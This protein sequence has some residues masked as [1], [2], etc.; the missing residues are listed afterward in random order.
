MNN[1]ISIERLIKNAKKK[2]IDFGKGDPY[3]RLRYYTKMGW[4]PHTVRKK[5]KKGDVK[6]HYPAWALDHLILIE[7]LKEKGLSNEEIAKRLSAKN[8]L[9]NFFDLL[10]DTNTRNLVLSYIAFGMIV[11]IFLTE[12]GLLK[13]GKTKDILFNPSITSVTAQILDSGNAFIPTNT[14]SVFIKTSFINRNMKVNVTFNQDYYPATRYWIEEIKDYEG[15]IIK[16]DSPVE[17]NPD[18]NWWVTN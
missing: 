10:K 12:M 17:N 7:E 4:L 2:G 9:V 13:I 16:L 18:F 6:G 11:I 5:D 3:N 14:D 8:K 1:L 15:F